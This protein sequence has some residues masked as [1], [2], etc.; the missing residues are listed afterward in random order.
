MKKLRVMFVLLVLTFFSAVCWGMGI[1][2]TWIANT[3]SDLA[4]YKI[5]YG[6][7]AGV[8]GTPVSVG[9]VTTYNL[10]GLADDTTYYIRMSA[11]DTAG[12][13]SAKNATEVSAKTRD[14]NAPAA[15]GKPTTKIIY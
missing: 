4:G 8:Y 6:T 7:A 10:T 2:V 11:Y 5:Y 15:P 14:V 1:E 12:N 13:E 3:E 9:K